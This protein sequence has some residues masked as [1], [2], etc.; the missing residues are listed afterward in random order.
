MSRDDKDVLG[1]ALA[2]AEYVALCVDTDVVQSTGAEFGGHELG[3]LLFVEGGCRNL[4]DLNLLRRV[5]VVVGAQIVERAL[6]LGL[7]QQ[8]VVCESD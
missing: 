4:A 3:A 6:D 5:A 2:P 8:R 7:G 1:C